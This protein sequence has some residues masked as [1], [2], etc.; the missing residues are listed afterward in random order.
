M[1]DPMLSDLP[2]TWQSVLNGSHGNESDPGTCTPM[3]LCVEE[4]CDTLQIDFPSRYATTKY[5]NV[6]D[7]AD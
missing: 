5:F 4:K 2:S 7:P 1:N 3:L 6:P